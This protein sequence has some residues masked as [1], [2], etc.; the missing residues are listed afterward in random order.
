L[1]VGL[2][3]DSGIGGMGC[4]SGFDCLATDPVLGELSLFLICSTVLVFCCIP[5]S[6]LLEEPGDP[7]FILSLGVMLAIAAEELDW[8][9][10]ISPDGIVLSDELLVMFPESTLAELLLLDTEPEDELPD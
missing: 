1:L 10:D 3:L 6:S 4:I 8:L 9:D 7:S 5:C 2:L